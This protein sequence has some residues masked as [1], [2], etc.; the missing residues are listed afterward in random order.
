MNGNLLSYTDDIDSEDEVGLIDLSTDNSGKGKKAA[1]VEPEN[2]EAEAEEVLTA[3]A[4]PALLEEADNLSQQGEFKEAVIRYESAYKVTPA[5]FRTV[6]GLARLYA[7]SGKLKRLIK[8]S[9]Q[10]MKQL[11]EEK[12]FELALL[13]AQAVMRFDLDSLEA[14]LGVLRCIKNSGDEDRYIQY[15]LDYSNYFIDIGSGELSIKVLQVALDAF[16]LRV[17]LAVKLADIHMQ[18]GNIQ[19][20]TKQCRNIASFY[21]NKNDY[22]HA[23]ELYRRLRMLLPEDLGVAL[24]LAELYSLTEEYEDSISVY[25]SCMH[26]AYDNREALMGLASASIAVGRHSD[27]S[28][29]LRKI[30]SNTPDDLE[31]RE[32]LA[33]VYVAIE[34]PSEAV[35]ELITASR[36]YIEAKEYDNGV[37]V[38]ERLLELDASNAYAVRELSNIKTII[39]QREARLAKMAEMANQV[40]AAEKVAPIVEAA[41]ED[42]LYADDGPVGGFDGELDD[43]EGGSDSSDKV[44]DDFL[45]LLAEVKPATESVAK[46]VSRPGSS[47]TRVLVGK[48]V[49]GKLQIPVPFVM[50]SYPD[51]IELMQK[52]IVEPPARDVLPWEYLAVLEADSVAVASAHEAAGAS[53]PSSDAPVQA[54]K[55]EVKSGPVASAFASSGVSMFGNGVF[56]AASVRSARG[57]SKKRRG[58]N[59]SRWESPADDM[60]EEE[61]RET[62][63]AMS[64]VQA[65]LV[66][67]FSKR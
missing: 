50:A 38:L 39:A 19:E 14:R 27:A 61:T 54:A 57:N 62:R 60:E 15:V 26:I 32:K 31:A 66:A 10:W 8:V 43:L 22:V 7:I 51:T 5:S 56:G 21:E 67:R 37:R 29:A 42:D 25:R 30:L 48:A 45:P 11:E 6:N 3:E 13:A 16:P 33:E 53:A 44:D 12:Q 58:R 9:L 49:P 4:I 65:A 28:L 35:N 20:C 63:G 24:R 64:S 40:K 17:E 2:Q 1:A 23:A 46:A 34:N 52:I 47:V 41:S 18:L 59:K 36:A 55:K